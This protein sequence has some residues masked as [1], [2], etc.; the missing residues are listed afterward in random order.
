MIAE[1]INPYGIRS[2]SQKGSESSS[3]RLSQFGTA[4]DH[5]EF[6]K[7]NESYWYNEKDGV[8]DDDDD[9][10]FMTPSFDGPDFFSSP[11]EDKFITISSE[12]DNQ[13]GNSQNFSHISDESHSVEENGDCIDKTCLPNNEVDQLKAGLVEKEVH[14]ND[15]DALANVTMDQTFG[16]YSSNGISKGN[17]DSY[18][19][20]IK[21]DEMNDLEDRD[22]KGLTKECN[23]SNDAGDITDD[24]ELTKYI[25]E[26][27]YE[28]FNL[29]IVHRKNRFVSC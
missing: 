11:T 2:S 12:M 16:F 13:K 29:R 9:Y 10:D 28:V 3:D 8:D 17:S 6:D 19:L 20:T 15:C 4:R 23:G 27:D 7:R 22:D 14:L 18:D 24:D 21:V 5:H 26:D 25:H 1:F